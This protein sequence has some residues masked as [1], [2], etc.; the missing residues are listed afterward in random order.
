MSF[1]AARLGWTVKNHGSCAVAAEVSWGRF[2]LTRRAFPHAVFSP[3]VMPRM[4]LACPENRPHDTG[5]PD[6]RPKPMW[7]PG[8]HRRPY[9]GVTAKTLHREETGLPRPLHCVQEVFRSRGVSRGQFSGHAAIAASH[10]YNA[11]FH[12]RTI[13]ACQRE[14]SPGHTRLLQM[15]F[16][17]ARL[18]WTAKKRTVRD[19]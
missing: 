13:P 8:G 14:P 10:P 17:A 9:Y 5:A 11:C 12:G 15:S 1:F 2:S 16:F 3:V 4:T 19:C 18:S 7:R 6:A